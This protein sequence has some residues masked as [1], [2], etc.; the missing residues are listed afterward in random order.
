[1]GATDPLSESTNA[2]II[3]DFKNGR[4]YYCSH[5]FISSLS[6]NAATATKL[7]SSINIGGVS[8]DGS[9]D[10]DLPGVNTKVI[11]TLPVMQRQRPSCRQHVLST[12]SRLMVLKILN[13]THGL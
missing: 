7:A 5:P 11:K 9:A 1:M 12:A 6:G 4:G 10:I 13:L 3:L 8:F 2:K